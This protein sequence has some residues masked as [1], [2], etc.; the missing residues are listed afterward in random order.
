[1]SAKTPHKAYTAMLERWQRCRDV[2][3]GQDAVQ[4]G[5]E[6]YLPRLKDQSEPDYLAYKKRGTF[7]NA[8]WRTIA[9]MLG[10]IFQKEPVVTVPAAM[11]EMMKDVTMTGVPIT[12]FLQNISEEALKV[13]RVGVLVDYPYVPSATAITQAD[14]AKQNLRP[15]LCFYCAESIINWRV[16]RVNNKA[17]LT[18]VVLKEFIEVPEVDAQGVASEFKRKVEERYRVLDLEPGTMKYRVRM[19]KCE[20]ERD[21]LE[22]EVVPL[23]RGL[24]MDYIPFQFIGPDDVTPEVDD[25]PLIDL[26]NVNLSHYRVTADYEHGCHFT[27]LPTA[28]IA[29]YKKKEGEKLYI[30]SSEA[31]VFEDS[32]AQAGYLEFTGQGLDSL[33][34]N[35]A[36]K[37]Q[38]MAILGARLLE[39]QKKSP[40][41]A[42]SASIRR[43]GEECVLS[44]IAVSISLGMTTVLA[45]FGDW[46]ETP[47]ETTCE[48]N[49]EF[50]PVPM[51]PQMLTAL[52]NGWQQGAM[53]DQ[54][55]FDNLQRGDVIAPDVTFEDEQAR[56]A[57]S[58]PKL[59]TPLPGAPAGNQPGQQPPAGATG[60]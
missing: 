36:N 14:A 27:G 54:V 57:N 9:G 1:M 52:V 60:G 41:A 21:E 30:G 43:K 58:G 42:D 51:T 2:A 46:A 13:G 22:S 17:A 37:E 18:L 29:G 53:S 4:A 49:D 44:S 19:F 8:T 33:A 34:K 40:E 24:P 59:A 26:V 12:V 47:G 28:W 20:G 48:L 32:A 15:S 50:F 38:Q 55:L 23:K 35:L 7:Y 10:M 5:G 11:E 56:I 25:P 6:K 45:W 3:E 31:W 39:P 16:G